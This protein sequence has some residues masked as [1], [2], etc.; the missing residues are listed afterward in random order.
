MVVFIVALAICGGAITNENHDIGV[1]V[2]GV[3]L[4]LCLPAPRDPSWRGMPMT[5][6]QISVE[7]I[8]VVESSG[9]SF[10][11]KLC[12]HEYLILPAPGACRTS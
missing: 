2:V 3:L 5:L 10:R 11:L 9:G 1:P 8:G 4:C 6:F 7:S 12:G